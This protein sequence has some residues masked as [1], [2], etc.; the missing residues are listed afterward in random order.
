MVALLGGELEHRHDVGF[1]TLKVL[2]DAFAADPERA[3]R[4]DRE[5]QAL[6]ALHHPNMAQIYD[7]GTVAD[8]SDLTAPGIVFLVMELVAGETVA[9]AYEVTRDEQDAFAAGSHKK[10]AAAHA[11]GT[12][13]AEILPVAIPQQKG[14]PVMFDKDESVRVDT[15]PEALRA[16]KPAFRK[17]GSVTAGNAPGRP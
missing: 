8:A 9:D 14:A 3:A 11:A 7:S 2:P 4:F 10:A 12:F 15:M 16:L 13:A 6:A 5:A 1:L 17:D